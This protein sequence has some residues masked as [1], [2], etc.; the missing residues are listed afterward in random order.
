VFRVEGLDLGERRRHDD[1]A[2][3]VRFQL[4]VQGWAV[5]SQKCAAVPRRARI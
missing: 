4:L 2:V 1:H 5:T 3:R